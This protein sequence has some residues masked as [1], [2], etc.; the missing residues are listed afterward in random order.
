MDKHSVIL[1]G[2]TEH[3]T[4][5]PILGYSVTIR[6][7]LPNQPSQALLLDPLAILPDSRK[8]ATPKQ[9]CIDL[10]ERPTVLIDKPKSTSSLSFPFILNF[11]GCKNLQGHRNKT[12]SG[13]IKA[14]LSICPRHPL[15]YVGFF[16]MSIY[17][18]TTLALNSKCATCI[19][20]CSPSAERALHAPL[21]Q[22]ERQKNDVDM[23][24][25]CSMGRKAF[26]RFA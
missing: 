14:S 20:P 24:H 26:H 16:G 25:G 4:V 1:L 10:A 13:F 15:R 17:I 22:R 21:V 18:A 19:F 8:R 9:D 5:N 6:C 2:S 3:T 23:I 7:I 11:W 12:C